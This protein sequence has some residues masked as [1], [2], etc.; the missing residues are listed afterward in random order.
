MLFG[1]QDLDFVYMK[2]KPIYI[3]FIFC[4]NKV[5]LLTFKLTAM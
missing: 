5:L 1:I 2:G 4:V 3:D